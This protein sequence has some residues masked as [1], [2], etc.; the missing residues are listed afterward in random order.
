MDI[1]IKDQYIS[2]ESEVLELCSEGENILI[3]S[4]EY[5]Y[6]GAPDD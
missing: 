5:Y 4:D 2:P 3:A 1:K 6:Q